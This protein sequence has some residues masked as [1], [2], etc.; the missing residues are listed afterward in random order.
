MSHFS[1]AVFT[2]ENTTVEDLLEPYDEGL[3]VEKYV[4]MTRND[5]IERGKKEIKYLLEVFGDYMKNK[6]KFRREHKN[7]IKYIRFVKKIPRMKRW[8]KE[9]IYKFS[10][11]YY[12]PDEIDK[13]GC[14]Y[15]TYNPNSK[16][17]WYLIGG[18]WKNMLI[19]KNGNKTNSAVVSEI[20][21][22]A[23]KKRD[24][25]NIIPY[26]EYLES[27]HCSK[28]KLLKMYPNEEEYK[29]KMSSFRT[30][31][32]IMPNGEWISPGQMG[33]WGISSASVD[34]EEKFYNNYEENILKKV[35]RNWELTIV[36]CHI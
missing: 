11:R 5:F 22:D 13:V 25:E 30:Y 4:Y 1:V 19:D 33:W 15:S 32:A 3:E 23:I 21:W 12:S 28:E 20:D 16:W 24:E 36:D 8:N 6:K 14:V 26:N 35:D 2:D 29:K 7:N 27:L 10:T 18:R 34:E 17:D 31:A 9:K